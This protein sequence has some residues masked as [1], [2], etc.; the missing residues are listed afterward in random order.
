MF[1]CDPGEIPDVPLHR[2]DE[3]VTVGDN[4]LDTDGRK[5]CDHVFRRRALVHLVACV[6][7]RALRTSRLD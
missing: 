1:A 7:R 4:R 6:L 5:F 2:P 3:I